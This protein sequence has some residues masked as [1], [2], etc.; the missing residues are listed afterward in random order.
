MKNIKNQK[1]LAQFIKTDEAFTTIFQFKGFNVWW[2]CYSEVCGVQSPST[3]YFRCDP[4]TD[5]Q[6]YDF[7]RLNEKRFCKYEFYLS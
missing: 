4:S 5:K 3:G 2:N 1:D 7:N 6:Y